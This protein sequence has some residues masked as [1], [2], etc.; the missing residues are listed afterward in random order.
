[1]PTKKS[2]M[3]CLYHRDVL[4]IYHSFY[5]ILI[6]LIHFIYIIAHFF[7]TTLKK[8][9]LLSPKRHGENFKSGAGA[10]CSQHPSE[11]AGSG[12]L[13]G[14][15]TRLCSEVCDCPGFVQPQQ[16]GSVMGSQPPN[17]RVLPASTTSMDLAE[18]HRLTLHKD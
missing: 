9:C 15:G 10:E 8:K 2:S 6:L 12:R 1:M 17:A 7:K 16:A 14:M 18:G 11:A 13:L 4:S 5:Y 3:S